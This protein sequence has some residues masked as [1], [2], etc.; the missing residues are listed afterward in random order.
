MAGSLNKVMLIGNVGADPEIRDLDAN[1]SVANLRIATSNSW[2]DKQTG[3][4]KEQTHWH[5]IVVWVD[6][7]VGIIEKY[8][9]KGSRIYVEGELQTRKWQDKDGND[10]YSTEVVLTGFDAKLLL[11]DKREG[12]GERDPNGN[13]D[14]PGNQSGGGYA[15]QSGGGRQ[16]QQRQQ[17]GEQQGRNPDETRSFS[18][19][20]DDEIPF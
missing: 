1:R 12:G 14:R 8:V 13:A 17:R 11:L 4:K 20:L 9:K 5:S 15:D 2:T 10:R 3:E 6:G 7:L 19:D 16:A 18:R